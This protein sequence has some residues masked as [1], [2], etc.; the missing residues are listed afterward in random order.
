MHQEASSTKIRVLLADDHEIVRNGIRRWL[1]RQADIDVVGTAVDGVE[2]V[3][4]ALRLRPDVV[5]MDV[6]MPR[7]TGIEATRQIR[8]EAPNIRIIGLSM[9]ENS[10]AGAAMR[11]AGVEEYLAKTC[12]PQ[13]L[14]AAIRQ[15][16][17]A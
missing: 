3:E 10:D 14:L 9:Y 5:V 15:C 13:E 11:E 2:A 7:M 4:Q 6:S 12:D 8:L 17:A 1:E 16:P